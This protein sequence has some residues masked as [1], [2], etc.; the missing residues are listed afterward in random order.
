M[1][2]LKNYF[3][4]LHPGE[5]FYVSSAEGGSSITTT[6][7]RCIEKLFEEMSSVA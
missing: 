3:P 6:K 1:E 4:S 2:R 5:E 7:K